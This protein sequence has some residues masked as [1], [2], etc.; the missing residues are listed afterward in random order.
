M[1]IYDEIVQYLAEHG[2]VEANREWTKEVS[3][4][5]NLIINGMPQSIPAVARLC[6]WCGGWVED[7]KSG[8]RTPYIQTEIVLEGEGG[9][10]LGSIQETL[11]EDDFEI[12]KRMVSL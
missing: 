2:W 10:V 11:F 9:R 4:S 8:E 1:K 3:I 12:F 7:V 6:I 5:N